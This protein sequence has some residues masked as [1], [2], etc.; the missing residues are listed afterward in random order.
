MRSA[1]RNVAIAAVLAVVVTFL[2]QWM[3]LAI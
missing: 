1:D 3:E 2:L